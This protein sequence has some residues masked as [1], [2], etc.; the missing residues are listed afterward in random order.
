MLDTKKALFQPYALWDFFFHLN[1][2]SEFEDGADN[3]P[4]FV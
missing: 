1:K 3:M 4:H 2:S